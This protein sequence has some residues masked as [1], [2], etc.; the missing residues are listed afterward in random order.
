M[1]VAIFLYI[2]GP[3][4][5]PAIIMF[6]DDFLLVTRV[7]VIDFE[8]PAAGLSKNHARFYLTH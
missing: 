1:T 4:N 2:A 7:L 3:V 5:G 8:L 6:L